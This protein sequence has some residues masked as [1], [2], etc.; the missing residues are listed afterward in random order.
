MSSDKQ[1]RRE[2]F[3]NEV[4]N[5]GALKA[6]LRRTLSDSYRASGYTGR[7]GSV[8]LLRYH[9]PVTGFFVVSANHSRNS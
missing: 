3:L 9:R 5:N 1:A 8:Q 4:C 6:L 2:E 7:K